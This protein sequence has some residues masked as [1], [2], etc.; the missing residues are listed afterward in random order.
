MKKITSLFMG[1][2]VFTSMTFA[3]NKMEPKKAEKAPAAKVEKMEAAK[4][5]P[6]KAP[7]VKKDGTPDKRFKA[8]KA[9]KAEV[10]TKKDGT[11]DMRFKKNKTAAKKPA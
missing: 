8:N 9:E 1:L 2:V 4:P 6:A 7:A 5:K 10:P 11:P 3:Q